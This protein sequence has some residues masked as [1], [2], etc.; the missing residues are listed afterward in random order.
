M[1]NPRKLEHVKPLAPHVADPSV[2]Y[3]DEV[4][5]PTIV[6]SFM[7]YCDMYYIIRASGNA[8]VGWLGSVT[9]LPDNRYRIDDVFLFRQQVSAVHCEFDA[10]DVGKFYHELLKE[11]PKNMEMLNR[12][13]FWGHLHP[14]NMTDPSHQD[15]EQ[16]KVFSDNPFFI[17]GI[18]TR[19]GLASFTFF[20]YEHRRK[21]VDCPW[22]FILPRDEEREASVV[23][24]IR[25]KVRRAPLLSVKPGHPPRLRQRSKV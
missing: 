9:V 12:I 14:G 16:M 5:P 18:F 20:D 23:L 19:S 25:E 17:R 15:E 10:E 7:A 2:E 6:V 21:V 22:E 24:E 3:M 11:D 1:K 4:V 8:E 13:M